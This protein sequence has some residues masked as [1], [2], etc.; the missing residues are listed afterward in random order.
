M[1]G[2]ANADIGEGTP[3]TSESNNFAGKN[4]CPTAIL[5][6]TMR[7]E[8]IG[9]VNPGLGTETVVLAA[10]APPDWI[11][12]V[13]PSVIALGPGEL[14]DALVRIGAPAGFLDYARVDISGNFQD[15]TPGVM[16]WTFH[17]ESSIPVGQ[18]TWGAIKALFSD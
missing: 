1:C 12:T 14:V 11:A 10:S 13:N 5:P 2:W 17:M 8:W 7:N 16:E 9:V 3:E 18:D 4:D 6:G 15:G